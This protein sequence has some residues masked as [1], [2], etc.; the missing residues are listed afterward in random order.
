MGRD[1]R[2]CFQ[3]TSDTTIG[4]CGADE[5]LPR[6]MDNLSVQAAALGGGA[7]DQECVQVVGEAER[8]AGLVRDGIIVA[9]Q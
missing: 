7:L 4:V 8:E 1:G 5:G 3:V 2:R 9:S 6:Q